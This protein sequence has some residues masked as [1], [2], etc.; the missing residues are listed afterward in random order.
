MCR[1]ACML[2][3]CILGMPTCAEAPQQQP[4]P[5]T[6][7]VSKQLAEPNI[8][9]TTP[10][11]EQPPFDLLYL[12]PANNN[13][14]LKLLPVPLPDRK[15]PQPL[16]RSGY[17]EI[18]LFDRPGERYR[19]PWQAVVQLKL[20]EQLLLEQAMKLIQEKRFDEAYDY[21]DYV[22]THYPNVSGFSEVE[23][24]FLIEEARATLAQGQSERA[25]ADLCRLSELNPNHPEL[26]NLIGQAVDT[27]VAQRWQKG[28][29]AA[30]RGVVETLSKLLPQH[31]AIQKFRQQWQT[32]AAELEKQVQQAL[33]EGNARHADR[34]VR[35][36]RQVWPQQPRLDQ[37][38]AE[39][40]KA[41]PRFQVGITQPGAR[42]DPTSLIDWGSRR[43]GRLIREALV[44]YTGPGPEGGEYQSAFLMWQLDA[45]K[46][47][48]T[49][50][51]RPERPRFADG[52]SYT[53]YDL[54]QQLA[55]RADR[56][57][58]GYFP[59]W[60]EVVAGIRISSPE[61]VI[62]HLR[63]VPLK[64]ESLL[65]CVPEPALI[66]ASAAKDR[67]PGVGPFVLAAEESSS[68]RW[69]FRRNT[70]TGTASDGGRPVPNG[71]AEIE[72]IAFPRC[73]DALRALR[74]GEIDIVDR[75]NPWELPLLA[76]ARDVTV[77]PYRVPLVHMLVPNLSKPLPGNRDFRR[78]ML[79]AIDRERILQSLLGGK[80]QSGCQVVSG[81]F[82]AGTSFGDPMG[83]A[84]D[85][86]IKPRDYQ[87][88]LALALSEIAFRQA[89]EV[90]NNRGL[91]PLKTREVVLAHP[92][93]EIAREACRQ[94]QEQ[95]RLI[96]W[97]VKLVEVSPEQPPPP[98]YDFLYVE[99]A[100]WEPEID[101]IRLIA[102][103]IPERQFLSPQ[104]ELALAILGSSA[105]WPTLGQRLR[106]LHHW[107]YDDLSVLPLWQLVDFYAY[108]SGIKGL[109]E[110]RVSLYQNVETW[111][112]APN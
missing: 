50:R 107:V 49:L 75:V 19:V 105:D 11:Y 34:L 87:P 25:F 104:V 86:Q 71:P 51:L 91:P 5:L 12:N 3:L 31:P 7:Q 111:Q 13:A 41:Y 21:L 59:P 74:E 28:E 52:R 108:R 10:L 54:A 103:L 40:R 101:V 78:A 33:A 93:H 32:E 67:F 95:W 89:Q 53:A 96:G 94:I 29:Y 90:A 35:K 26:S 83:Y 36:L 70:H 56:H 47:T 77:Q 24:L 110:P 42:P 9:T 46:Q 27:L 17:L 106:D 23:Q 100:I 76:Q 112:F 73:R 68:S 8:D 88:S 84:Y 16:P 82:P 2:V 57:H 18:E 38:I 30:A 109:G 43:C 69:V 55:N 4:T 37:L 6:P 48:L 22:A 97:T 79:Y 98:E 60:A 44:E 1:T 99:A 20:F 39:V 15:V 81:P 80:P 14:V 85:P 61:E 65:Q 72:E 92:P 45:E 62:V 66:L 102:N 64:P 58:E 63:F